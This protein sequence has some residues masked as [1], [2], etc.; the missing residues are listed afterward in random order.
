MRVCLMVEGQEGVSWAEWVAL[1]EACERA[2]LDGLF[3]SDHYLSV[4]GRRERE[5]LD[6]WATLADGGAD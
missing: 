2:G 5:S 6:A 4:I 3:R 1:A